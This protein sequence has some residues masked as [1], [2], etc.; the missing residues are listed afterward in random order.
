MIDASPAAATQDTTPTFAYSSDEAG[1]TF[2][3]RLDGGPWIAGPGPVTLGPLQGTYTFEVQA[4]DAAGNVDATPA[5]FV[6]TVD[7]TPADTTIT[8]A[9]AA[10]TNATGAAFAF[11]ASDGGPSFECRS[12]VLCFAACTSPEPYSGLAESAHAFAVRAKDAAGNL[13]P[14]P[15]VHAWT[16]DTTAPDTSFLSTPATPSSNATPSFGLGSTE[17][18]ATFECTRLRRLGL[19]RDPVHDSRAR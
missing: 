10:S 16:V 15:A 3:H 17:A 14:T 7:T 2:E 9:P 4:T 5:A 1:A 18:P 19:L 12:T 6:F 13:D 11:T 8:S